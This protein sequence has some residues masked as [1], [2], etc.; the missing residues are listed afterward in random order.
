MSTCLLQ[1]FPAPR[2][3]W[4]REEY[5]GELAQK[6]ENLTISGDVAQEDCEITRQTAGGL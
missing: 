4:V 3:F 1:S 6:C 2:L 5:L